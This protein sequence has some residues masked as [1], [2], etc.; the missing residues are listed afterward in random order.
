MLFR[1]EI[2]EDLVL[3]EVT[4]VT[5]VLRRLRGHGIRVAIDDFGSGYSAL[6]YLRDLPIDEVKMDRHFVA[7]VATNA[8]AAAVVR[9]VIELTHDLG[10]TVVAEGIEDAETADWLRQHGCD[11]GQGY[12]F[13]RPV[14][15]DQ[16]PLLVTGN[17]QLAT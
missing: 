9:A 11:I 5:A 2:T 3:S 1:S 4:L 12:H 6:S 10:I 17:A 7:S 14:D 13:G 8:R 15:P 16:I